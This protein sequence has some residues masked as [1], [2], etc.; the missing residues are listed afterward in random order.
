MHD[1][2]TSFVRS[3]KLI[4]AELIGEELGSLTNFGRGQARQ[5]SA[6]TLS[7]TNINFSHSK[8]QRT[9]SID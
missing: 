9:H 1:L 4:E 7:I 6:T 3:L 2:S 8:L 5:S